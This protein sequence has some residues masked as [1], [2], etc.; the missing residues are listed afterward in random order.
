MPTSLPSDHHRSISTTVQIVEKVLNEMEELL[1]HRNK[2][3]TSIITESFTQQ[4]KQE[5]ILKI[6]ELK[7]LNQE[8]FQNYNLTRTEQTE[9]QIVRA[10]TAYL[11]TVLM[12]ST[13]K[14]MKGF[15]KIPAEAA[16]TLD[17]H[18]NKM[19]ILLKEITEKI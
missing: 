18:I 19:L 2:N 8:L 6:A 5:L 10:Q 9:L 13:S 11:W 12:D 7:K 17:E 15:G 1:Q 16:E 3:I 14:K 4:E